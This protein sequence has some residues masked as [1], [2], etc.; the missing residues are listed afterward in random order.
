MTSASR[1]RHR[2]SETVPFPTLKNKIRIFLEKT[3]ILFYSEIPML[4]KKKGPIYVGG[5]IPDEAGTFLD[6][7]RDYQKEEEE[8]T[9]RKTKYFPRSVILIAANIE[10]GGR[11]KYIDIPA[12]TPVFKCLM[13]ERGFLS[14][15]GPE[16]TGRAATIIINPPEEETVKKIYVNLKGAAKI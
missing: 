10:A 6:E 12:G 14:S 1:P 15:I 7:V 9:Y 8:R 2:P 11:G 3:D 13:N 16:F 4:E 5:A